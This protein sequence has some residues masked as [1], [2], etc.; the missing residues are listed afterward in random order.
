MK[1]AYVHLRV[2]ASTKGR[3]VR[4]SRA[5][6]MRLTDWIIRRVDM[7]TANDIITLITED[8]GHYDKKQVLDALS[9]GEALAALGLTDE[10]TE[11]V[12]EA[13]DIVL[14]S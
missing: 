12:E 6:G 9:D 1:E 8:L 13:Y 10:D 14:K 11:E 5:E 4:E 2:P 3:W 7:K